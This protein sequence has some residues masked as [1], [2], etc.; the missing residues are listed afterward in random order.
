MSVGPFARLESVPFWRSLYTSELD[1]AARHERDSVDAARWGND[2]QRRFADG[3]RES[4]LMRAR[5]SLILAFNAV[6]SSSQC[7]SPLDALERA[8]R[9][10]WWTEYRSEVN[11]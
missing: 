11:A 4:A 1:V 7:A 9:V 2:G 8:E 6:I 10:L 5:R 3:K